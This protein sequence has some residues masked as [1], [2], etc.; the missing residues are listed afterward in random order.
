[1]TGHSERY[2][3]ATGTGEVERLRLLQEVYGPKE[4]TLATDPRTAVDALVEIIG[5][6][7]PKK[8]TRILGH[9]VQALAN[10]GSWA[11]GQ[12]SVIEGLAGNDPTLDSQIDTAVA[13]IEQAA[14]TAQAAKAAAAKAKA[15]AP[16][17]PAAGAAP[18]APANP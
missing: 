10:A 15:A 16:A 4:A 6:Y 12:V 9:A 3:L 11:I 7:D 17:A 18:A 2:I 1:M 8:D 13:A 14:Q 5:K